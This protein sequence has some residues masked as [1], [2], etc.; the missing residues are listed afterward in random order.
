[1]KNK[2]KIYKVTGSTMFHKDTD[3]EDYSA[4]FMTEC[5]WTTDKAKAQKVFDAAHIDMFD[6]STKRQDGTAD[7]IFALQNGGVPVVEF[8]E[9]E[10]SKFHWD[11]REKLAVS[12][13]YSGTLKDGKYD[14]GVDS[15][16]FDA[17][18]YGYITTQNKEL[19]WKE[20]KLADIASWWT[21]NNKSLKSLYYS[22]KK[23][24][25]DK[26]ISM[27]KF[28]VYM[29]SQSNLKHAAHNDNG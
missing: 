5:A 13:G 18:D 24:S 12:G 27:A 15:F 22:Y 1:M 16:L 28:V 21:K 11:N 26:K 8:L 25:G 10:V 29:Y 7:Y 4:P 3:H 23:E 9:G 2:I 14:D 6:Y 20:K 17:T 19:E